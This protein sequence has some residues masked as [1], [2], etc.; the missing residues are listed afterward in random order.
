MVDLPRREQTERGKEKVDGLHLLLLHLL[1]RENHPSSSSFEKERRTLPSGSHPAPP[2]VPVYCNR[3]GE[4]VPARCALRR[5]KLHYKVCTT[6]CTLRRC[7][8]RWGGRMAGWGG[9]RELQCREDCGAGAGEAGQKRL[10]PNSGC[11]GEQHKRTQAWRHGE[12]SVKTGI[13]KFGKI[14]GGVK[15]MT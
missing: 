3:W 7:T 10:R 1:E 12:L 2:H 14:F 6:R 11:N 13:C 9:S 4:R 15:M 5:S 8:T